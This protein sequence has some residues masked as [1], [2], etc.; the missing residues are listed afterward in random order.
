M[1]EE[2]DATP[3][4]ASFVEDGVNF[5]IFS[6]GAE[7]V[8]LCLF[9]AYDNETDRLMIGH[10]TDGVWHAFLPG[11]RPGQRYGYRMHGRYAP[12]EGLRYNAHK[13]LIDPYARKLS[14]DFRWS[15]AVFDFDL[16]GDALHLNRL[17]SAAIV[18]KCVVT[19]GRGHAARGRPI[20]PWPDMVVYEANVR[21]YTMRHPDVPEAERGTFRGMTNA[22]ILAYLKSLGITSV[23][24]MP[25][26]EFIDEQFLIERGLRN[27]W[28]YN[29]ISFFVPARRYGCVDAREEFLGMVNAI[30]DA[31]ME[32][33]L[34]IAYNHTGESDRLGP[35][36]SF[37]GIDNRSY[38]RTPADDPGDYINDTGCGNTIN[39]DHPR[40]RTLIIDNLRFWVSDMRVDGFRFDL[41]T[42]L[43]RTADGFTSRHPLLQAIDND[44][45]L[46]G[47]KLIAEPWD[48]GPDGYQL[49]RFPVGW[50]EWNDRYRDSLR[51]FWRGDPNEM[52]EFAKRLLGSAD[53]FEAGGRSP[54]ASINFLTAHDGFTLADLVTY[55]KRHNEANGED[56][57][58]GHSHNFSTNFGIEGKTDDATIK[59]LRR[60]QRLNLLAT[61]L[62]SQG[63]PMLLAGDEFGNSQQGNNNA[64]AQDNEIGWLDWS[65]LDSDADFRTAV[66]ELIRL[67][68][69]IPLFRQRRFLHGRPGR[70]GGYRDAE[71][72]RCDGKPMQPE[73]WPAAGAAGL[74]LA[75]TRPVPA[76][77]VQALALL[78]N[79]TEED[80]QFALPPSDD[81][82]DWQVAFSTATVVTRSAADSTRHL[83]ARSLIC[84]TL[85]G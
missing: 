84:L 60:T 16:A 6:A 10:H 5:A 72:L 26:Q 83:S 76:D 71:W 17:D 33:L 2:G 77:G 34:D 65:G 67:R 79:P 62:L 85:S 58:D 78:M 55:E 38:Y 1:I 18:P 74:I 9:D 31:G 52:G 82:K 68:K 28:G 59:R 27:F 21:G 7:A 57:R 53:I 40:V 54:D 14:G 25:V 73:D 63:T 75:T 42:V 24:L 39:V 8:E 3:T 81:G 70:P 69:D 45:V 12:H 19:S 11:C 64:Y 13:L 56:N 36:L 46:R 22:K 29:T 61:L 47:A 50:A 44:A 30:H 4:G 32:V 66:R 15:P 51:R 48:T 41:A 35:T 20:I 23:E 49:G 80:V 43:G 37:R